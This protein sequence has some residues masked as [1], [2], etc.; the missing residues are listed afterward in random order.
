MLHT[1][2]GAIMP[3]IGSL[4]LFEILIIL[5][6]VLL[7]F[8]PKRLPDM[9]RGLGQSIREFR[10]SVR[11]VQKDIQDDKEAEAVQAKTAEPSDSNQQS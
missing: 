1:D 9:A 5:V 6:A 7:I 3:K 8:G 4:G 11:D 2:G 10:K